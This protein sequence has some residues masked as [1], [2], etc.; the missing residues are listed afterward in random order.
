MIGYLRG[1]L[2]HR[3]GNQAVLV[4]QGVGYLIQATEGALDA[5]ATQ[6]PV[7]VWVSTQVR[8]DAITLYAFDS[9]ATRSAF[10]ILLTV[11]GVGPKLALAALN[12]HT[13]SSLS[14]AVDGEDL[15]ALCQVPGIG[16]RTAQRM[17][18]ELK[19]KLP[20]TEVSIDAG[21]REP[22]STDTLD[23]ALRRLGYNR[24]EVERV[25]AQLP[26]QGLG[27]DAPIEHR[28]KAALRI[29]YGK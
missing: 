27:P 17:V 4:V 11:S 3:D 2:H 7:E 6:D 24:H 26:E 15:T 21:P 10:E 12:L 8:E 28:L 25:K 20:A 1:S 13:V 18:L 14:Q 5:W 16:K 19:N 23:L 29:L 9:W 22:E